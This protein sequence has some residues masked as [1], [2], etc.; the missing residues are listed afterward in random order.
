MAAHEAEQS[1]GLKYPFVR[2]KHVKQSGS[3]D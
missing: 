3:E 1:V 2:A